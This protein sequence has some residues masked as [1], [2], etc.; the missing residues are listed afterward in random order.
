MFYSP[1]NGNG[2]GRMN[3]T[4]ALQMLRSDLDIVHVIKKRRLW[5]LGYLFWMHE[6]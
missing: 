1:I 2:M 5:C 6:I 4:N 3:Y